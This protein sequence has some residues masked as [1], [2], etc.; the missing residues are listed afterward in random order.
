MAPYLQS[1]HK[2]VKLCVQLS[3]EAIIHSYEPLRWFYSITYVSV[4]IQVDTFK[5][6]QA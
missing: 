5:Y 2:F 3:Y 1:I 4:D 6:W